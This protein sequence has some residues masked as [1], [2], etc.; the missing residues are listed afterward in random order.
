MLD[1]FFASQKPRKRKRTT[2]G[3]SSSGG[4]PSKTAL[5]G[6]GQTAPANPKRKAR[7]EELASDATDDDVAMDAIDDMDLRA[8]EP[9]PGASEEED[10]AEAPA[11]KRLRLARLYLDSIKE[12]LGAF[13]DWVNLGPTCNAEHIF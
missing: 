13:P 7:D 12:G 11:E 4:R 8:E 2:A 1:P 5:T 6:K 9:D 10:E 3:P